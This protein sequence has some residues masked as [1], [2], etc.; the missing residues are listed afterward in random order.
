[1]S[2]TFNSATDILD[3]SGKVIVVTGGNAGL[4]A[5]TIRQLAVH[6]PA[7]IFLCARSVPKADALISEV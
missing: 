3:L 6:N 4:G 1:M 2:Q 5:E 7:K